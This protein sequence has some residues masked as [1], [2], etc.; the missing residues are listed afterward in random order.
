MV[1][2]VPDTKTYPNTHLFDVSEYSSIVLL[3]Q[4]TY[5]GYNVHQNLRGSGY[6]N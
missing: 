1:L 5:G 2:I 4:H 6:K 3:G